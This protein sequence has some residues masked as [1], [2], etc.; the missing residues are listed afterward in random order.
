MKVALVCLL[1]LDV[2]LES[3][4]T[5]D[6]SKFLRDLLLTQLVDF[7]LCVVGQK[8]ELDALLLVEILLDDLV[9]DLA[10]FLSEFSFSESFALEARLLTVVHGECKLRK[11]LWE[12]GVKHRF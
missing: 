5:R 11:E 8:L 10:Y 4:D 9:H 1:V 7:L 3:L 12:H 2:V 6:E